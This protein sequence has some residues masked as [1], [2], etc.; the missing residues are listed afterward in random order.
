M[1]YDLTAAADFM[2][3]HARILDRRRFELLMGETEPAGVLAALDGYRNSDGGY[4]WGLE[5]D[6]R[7]P[8]SQTGAA[9]HAFEVFEEI[10]PATAPQAVALCDWLGSVTLPDGGLPFALPLETTAGSARW[11]TNSDP[12]QSSL[13]ISSIVT[14]N[15][16]RVAHHDSEVAAHPWLERATAYCVNAIEAMQEAPFAFVLGFS[17]RFVDALHAWQPET[18]ARLLDHLRRF[19]PADGRVR[20]TGG[21]EDEMFHPLDI[22][23]HPGIART[24]FSDELIKTD[25]ERIVGLQQDDGGWVVDFP[26]ASPAASL[27]WRGYATVQ[28]VQIL[29]A[30]ETVGI[31]PTSAGA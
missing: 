11:W 22:A 14:A 31:E 28:A 7:S 6:L 16:L 1:N 18:A 8:E 19:V 20:V 17:I 4:G 25:L 21:A 12:T 5:A 26:S 29:R 27:E 2:A 30:V 23:P 13:Q 9:L 3:A 24:L 10:A 15:A